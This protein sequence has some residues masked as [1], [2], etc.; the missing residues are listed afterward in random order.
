MAAQIAARKPHEK[1]RQ[2]G[3]GGLALDRLENLGNYHPLSTGAVRKTSSVQSI[4]PDF[5]PLREGCG[6]LGSGSVWSRA[7]DTVSAD[8][9]LAASL[10]DPDKF[11]RPCIKL[12]HSLS[13]PILPKW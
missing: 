2:A 4:L 3:V 8:R 13:L 6:E 7:G 9:Q 11:R 5:S 10:L 12:S 1:A